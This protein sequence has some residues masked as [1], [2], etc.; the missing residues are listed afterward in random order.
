MIHTTSWDARLSDDLY[1]FQMLQ[2]MTI[3]NTQ[4]VLSLDAYSTDIYIF[5][6]FLITPFGNSYL[7]TSI[8]VPHISIFL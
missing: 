8:C 7:N 5:K 3:V 2:N 6:M 4:A 1:L